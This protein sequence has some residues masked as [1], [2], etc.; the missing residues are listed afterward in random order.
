MAGEGDTERLIVPLRRGL[1]DFERNMLKAP[2]VSQ[3]NFNAIK[4]MS[5][6]ATQQ[7][8]QDMV[9]STNR[10]NQALAST[11]PKIG[12]FGKAAVGGFVGSQPAG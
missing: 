9:R 5:K 10:I 12:S 1:T 6:S 4:H 7:M 11:F 3:K 2:G 8:E